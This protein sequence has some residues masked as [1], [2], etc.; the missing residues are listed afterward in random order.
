ML[1][2]VLFY[3]VVIANLIFHF[4]AITTNRDKALQGPDFRYFGSSLSSIYVH[5]FYL[6]GYTS[7]PYYLAR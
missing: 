3:L 5:L 7:C 1:G 2:N 6:L 4:L